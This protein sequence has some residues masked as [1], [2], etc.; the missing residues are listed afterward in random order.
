MDYHYVATLWA[1]GLECEQLRS[2]YVRTGELRKRAQVEY[3]APK[4][5][6]VHH[7]ALDLYAKANEVALTEVFTADIEVKHPKQLCWEF[8]INGQMVRV[9]LAPQ[10]DFSR[11]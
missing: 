8:Y 10:T 9:E 5:L 11:S 3:K 6:D 1:E 2:G 7:I 4:L